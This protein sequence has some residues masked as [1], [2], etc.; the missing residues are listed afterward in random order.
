V[1]R[2]FDRWFEP[3]SYPAGP[4]RGGGRPVCSH[5]A[6]MRRAAVDDVIPL[7]SSARDVACREGR[8]VRAVTVRIAFGGA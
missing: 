2:C 1:C 3:I 8:L 6:W 7:V 4:V 5:D